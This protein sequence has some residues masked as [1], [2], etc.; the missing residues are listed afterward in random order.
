[1]ASTSSSVGV[2]FLLLLG[3]AVVVEDLLRP[4][5]TG[6][7]VEAMSDNDDEDASSSDD[8]ADAS[9]RQIVDA[10]VDDARTVVRRRTIG[11][12]HHLSL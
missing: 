7:G 3:L 11:G 5:G 8:A 4:S 10:L 9:F 2:L 6:A 12:C 1:M